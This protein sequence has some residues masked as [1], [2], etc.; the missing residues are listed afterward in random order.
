[1]ARVVRHLVLDNEAAQALLQGG[2]APHPKRAQVLLAVAAANGRRVV[3][4]A[5]RGE[6]GWDRGQAVSADANRL[7]S[8]DSPFDAA[9]AN[10]A[11]QL[12]ALTP[13][14]SVVDASVAVAAERIGQGG[15]V[16]VLTSDVPDQK[17]L[18][19]NVAVDVI[20]VGL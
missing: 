11:V 13:G 12:M 8:E 14:A 2:A 16:E 19:A 9:A 17:G 20:V 4:T 5:V 7:V 10:R 18:A 1:M 6:A 15:V 3:P